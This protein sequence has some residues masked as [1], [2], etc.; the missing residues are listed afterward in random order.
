MK[1]FKMA[2]WK[3]KFL[4]QRPLPLLFSLVSSPHS[5]AF[6]ISLSPLPVPSS[7]LCS[8]IPIIEQES[9]SNQT[10]S[11][12]HFTQ[13]HYPSSSIHLPLILSTSLCNI[14]NPTNSHI[15][16]ITSI[17]RPCNVGPL[18]PTHSINESEF[19]S[20]TSSCMEEIPYST[21]IVLC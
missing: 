15:P 2:L 20:I 8:L 18:S 9:N 5:H 1:C 16:L 7:I 4:F 14:P 13:S 6:P 3:Q 19:A 21:K 11:I 17:T 10:S 12:F